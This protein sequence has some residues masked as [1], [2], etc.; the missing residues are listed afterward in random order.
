MDGTTWGM[1]SKERSIA[2]FNG[3]GGGYMFAAGCAMPCGTLIG[4]IRAMVE[5]SRSIRTYN[6]AFAGVTKS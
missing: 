2:V 6:E 5:V 1:D 3:E 4:N